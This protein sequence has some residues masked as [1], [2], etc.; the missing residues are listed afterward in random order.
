MMMNDHSMLFEN[1]INQPPNKAL[2]SVP[3]DHDVTPQRCLPMV[4]DDI[5]SEYSYA[6][7]EF[8]SMSIEDDSAVTT[9]VD[10]KTRPSYTPDESSEYCYATVTSRPMAVG[11]KGGISIPVRTEKALIDFSIS[12]GE[13]EDAEAKEID[14]T[15]PEDFL[16]TTV[17]N[18]VYALVN[19]PPKYPAASSSN[20][21]KQQPMASN[22]IKQSPTSAVVHSQERRSSYDMVADPIQQENTVNPNIEDLYAAV[23]KPPKSNVNGVI[24]HHNKPTVFNNS[25]TLAPFNNNNNNVIYPAG[26]KPGKKR[27]SDGMLNTKYFS[28]VV[29]RK[30]PPIPRPYA[31]G[32]LIV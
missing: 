30:P 9:I 12:G 25:N 7:V 6:S 21:K 14:S 5:A 23:Q 8:R 27:V 31:K 11:M 17:N 3:S 13:N 1:N 28:N 10:D 15:D 4:P 24:S 32:I 20:T 2:P 19:K 18:D 26:F 22:S 16:H 29:G